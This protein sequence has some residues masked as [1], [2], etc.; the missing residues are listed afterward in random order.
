MNYVFI[1]D[2]SMSMTQ[3]ASNQL[4]FLEV[5]KNFVESFIMTRA[6]MSEG[7]GD[8]FF[9]MSTDTEERTEFKDFAFI[10]DVA[11]IIWDLR[12][13]KSS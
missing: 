4:S 13:I 7:K 6:K 9:V 1:I 12:S 3:R 10:N 8:K 2:C 11:H 5:A